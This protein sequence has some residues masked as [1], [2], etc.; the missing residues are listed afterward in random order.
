MAW[1]KDLSKYVRVYEYDGIVNHMVGLYPLHIDSNGDLYIDEYKYFRTRLLTHG[2][3]EDQPSCRWEP[4]LR[5]PCTCC[6][7]H[8]PSPSRPCGGA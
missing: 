1:F 6:K 3:M 7:Q 5:P 4:A 8:S 2:E